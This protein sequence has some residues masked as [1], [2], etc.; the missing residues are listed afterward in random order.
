M[1]VHPCGY[2]A[3]KQQRASSHAR[4]QDDR[5]LLGLLKQAWLEIGCIDGYRKLRLDMREKP[6]RPVISDVECLLLQTGYFRRR[7]LPS[8][9]SKR[10]VT[11]FPAKF[12]ASPAPSPSKP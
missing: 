9:V 10:L 2:Y 3:W 4:D 5:R 1:A 12:P 7:K 6:R 11:R 8:N